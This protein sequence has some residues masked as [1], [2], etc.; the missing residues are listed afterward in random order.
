MDIAKE[1]KI[2]I[3]QE[4]YKWK[5]SKKELSFELREEITRL[6]NI[7]IKNNIAYKIPA[8]KKP[9]TRKKRI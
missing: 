7:C 1:V 8:R 5:Q 6:E 9:A 3:N 4:I 2:M